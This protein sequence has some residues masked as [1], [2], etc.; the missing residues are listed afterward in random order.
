MPI[1]S[2]VLV[3]GGGLAGMTAGIAAAKAGATVTVV[4]ATESTLRQASGLIDVLGYPTPG[5]GPIADPYAGISLL[6]ESHPYQ[7]LGAENIADG[8]SLFDEVTGELYAGE[9]RNALLPTAAGTLKPTSRYPATMQAGLLSDPRSTVLLGFDGIVDVRGPLAADR[10]AASDVPCSIRGE[11][12]EFPADFRSDA[13]ITRYARALDRNETVNVDGE[14]TP[15][16]EA[17]TAKIEPLV[18]DADRIGLPAILGLDAPSAIKT[19]LEAALDTAVFE[20]PMGP[21]S[22]PGI[23][24]AS[25][26]ESALREAGGSYHG[27][28][29]VID[30]ESQGDLITAVTVDRNGSRIPYT[31]DAYVL[32]TGGLVGHGI[33]TTREAVTEPIFG[34]YV[35][36]PTDRYEWFEDTA[37]G[38]HRFPAFGVAVDSSLRPRNASGSVEFENLWAAGAVIGGFDFAAE[39]SGSG[40]SIATGRIAGIEATGGS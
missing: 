11:M 35:E 24:L 3:I 40:I 37:F 39:N 30:Y 9:N 14:D 13:K 7:M 5:D 23:R 2:D 27:G 29:P 12:C 36:A 20:L 25:R 38:R 31:A 1:R 10:L 18:G 32:A 33:E 22:I 4:S 34:C 8:L 15:V 26:L 21:P 19:A 17:L 28:V 6:P 16:R